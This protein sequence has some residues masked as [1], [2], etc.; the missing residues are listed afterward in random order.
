MNDLK[1]DAAEGLKELR[2]P[3]EGELEAVFIFPAELAVFSGHFPGRPLVPGVLELEMARAVMERFTGAPLRIVSVDRAKF[4]RE[5][6]P[7]ER[8]D[9][10]LA[11][12]CSGGRFTVKARSAVGP[13]KAAHVE[14]TLEKDS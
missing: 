10:L 2:N 9:A 7:G 3:R 1:S 4:L 12:S 13:E 14:L 11:F 8:I 5:V 6:K